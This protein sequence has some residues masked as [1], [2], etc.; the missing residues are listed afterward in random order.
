MSNNCITPSKLLPTNQIQKFLRGFHF[1]EALRMPSFE[2]IKC[3]GNGENTLSF[4]DVVI[5]P[6]PQIFNVEN[7]SFNAIREN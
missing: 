4:T 5:M 7:I 1:R 3:L 6:N 2:K